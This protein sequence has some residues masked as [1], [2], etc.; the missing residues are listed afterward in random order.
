MFTIIFGVVVI[1]LYFNLLGRIESLEDLVK[2]LNKGTTPKTTP[3]VAGDITPERIEQIRTEVGLSAAP[4]KQVDSSLDKFGSWLKDDWPL[5]FGVLLLIIGFGWFTTYAFAH[6]WIGPVG[7]ITLGLIAGVFFLLL[8]NWRIKNFLHQG[9]AF[10]VLGSTTILLTIFA[11]REV[12]DFFTPVTALSLM[13]LSTAFVAFVSVKNNNKELALVSLVFAGIAPLLT[14]APTNDYVSLFTYLLVVILGAIWITALTGR[15]ELTTA[16]LILVSF[17]SLPHLFWY[18]S[19]DKATLLL[20]AYA[21]SSIF[22]L[23]N[24]SAL[25]KKKSE[26]ITSDIVTAF[27][28]GIFLLAWIFNAAQDEWKSIVISAWMIVF[29]SG[30]YLIYKF[31]NR[32]DAFYTYASLGIAMIVA[33]TSAELDGASLAIAYAIESGLV[34]L[35]IYYALRDLRVASRASLLLAGPIILSLQS[36]TS[37]AWL[38]NALNKDFFVLLVVGLVAFIL[39]IFFWQKNKN[40]EDKEFLDVGPLFIKVA[41]IYGYAL[42]W[43]VLHSTLGEDD[44]AVMISLVIYTIVGIVTYF[45]GKL[46]NKNSFRVYGGILLGCVIARLFLVDVWN[47]EL[48]GR[49]ITFFLLGALL[50]S[51]AFIGKGKGS[52]ENNSNLH[53]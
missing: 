24:I 52:L 45:Y 1:I 53:I 12:Y 49:I 27:G 34:S 30:A 4:V 32:K 5:K 31:N 37:E 43:K 11:A 42:I 8:G 33:A 10:L 19:S 29:V 13:F 17:Y 48:T 51:T 38:T 2:G 44:I 35:V 23:T 14:N 21:F 22:F 9:G 46:E 6:N 3:S 28:N 25:L 41:S 47:M 39:G 36:W 20:F 15:R 7:R 18:T 16:A 50:V 40:N 26:E